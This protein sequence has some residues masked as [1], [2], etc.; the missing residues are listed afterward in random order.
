MSGH[1]SDLFIV[2]A[3]LVLDSSESETPGDTL[4]RAVL[5][6]GDFRG[7][8]FAPEGQRAASFLRGETMAT[9]LSLVH[10]HFTEAAGAPNSWLSTS[11]DTDGPHRLVFLGIHLGRDDE[12]IDLEW[13]VGLEVMPR[14]VTEL[15]PMVAFMNGRL[16]DV[17]RSVLP[18]RTTYAGPGLP[19]EFVPWN[20]VDGSRLVGDTKRWLSALPAAR[21]GPLG[22]GWLIQSVE[23]LRDDLPAGF[24]EVLDNLRPPI[25][26]RDPIVS[27]RP[28]GRQ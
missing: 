22:K 24:A 26:Y 2:E 11:V 7:A 17:E 4:R 20:Y 25:Q 15:T 13:R 21:S 12:Q 6:L 3:K 9:R 27:S 23:T 8:P 16:V 18:N 28:R 10:P 14:L 5:A 1:I 19:T